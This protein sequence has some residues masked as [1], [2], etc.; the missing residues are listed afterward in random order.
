MRRR[1]FLT[2]CAVPLTG[3]TGIGTEVTTDTVVERLVVEDGTRLRV[4]VENGDVSVSRA[5]GDEMVIEANRRTTE[6]E[7]GLDEIQ[8][9]TDE[10]D[11]ELTVT[12]DYPETES[13][14]ERYAV[15]I[16]VSVPAGVVLERAE[17]ANGGVNVSDVSGEASP[18]LVSANG[19]VRAENIDGYVSLRSTNGSIEATGVVGITRASTVN[20][21]VD[22][23]IRE[24]RRPAVIESSQGNVTVHVAETVEAE[25]VLRTTNGSVDTGNVPLEDVNRDDGVRGVLNGGGSTVE[26]TTKNGNV[27]LRLLD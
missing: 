24:V 3:C 20:G 19:A 22:V 17:S 12:A 16:D 15:D 13:F 11:G 8:L 9:I 5:E 1:V 25:F 26:A 2:A 10:S 6:G 21:S 18:Q 23:E 27:S 4:V 14:G 7:E